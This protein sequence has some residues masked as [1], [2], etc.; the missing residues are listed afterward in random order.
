MTGEE[1]L[2]ERDGPVLRVTLNRPDHLNAVTASVLDGVTEAVSQAAADQAI[3]VL[4]LTGAGRAFCSGADLA[5][6]SGGDSTLHSAN[7][8]VLALRE[9]GKPVVAAVNGLA[10]GVGCSLALAGDL[11]MARNSAYF[12]LAFVNIGLMPDGGAT[13]LVPAAIGRARA[14]RM[15]LLAERIPAAQAADWGLI[16]HVV[17]DDSYDEEVAAV[18]GKL[19]QGPPLAYAETKRAINA[20]TIDNLLAAIDRETAG[21]ADLLRSQDVAEGVAAFLARRQPKFSGF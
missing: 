13:M 3:R 9:L 17:D 6:P 21:Q 19:V 20:T 14:M 18:V 5:G 2:V 11:V 7:R 1:L 15:A 16:S 4:V 10:A 8:A 12:L